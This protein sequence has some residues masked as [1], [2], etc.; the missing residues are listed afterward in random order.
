MSSKW[1]R[2]TAL[3]KGAT[4]DK[5]MPTAEDSPRSLPVRERNP[6][7]IFWICVFL[8]AMV[9]VVF[10]QT[11]RFDFVNF[12]DGQYVT[13]NPAVTSG[14]TTHGVV[15]AFSWH[16]TDNWV[17]LTTISHM[18]DCQFYGVDASGHHFTNILLHAATVILLFLTL[19]RMAGAAWR[20]A[21]VTALFAIHPLRAESVGWVSERKDVLC[22]FFFMLTL[23]TYAGYARNPR[24]VVRYVTA[25]FFAALALMSK[26]VA[27]TLPCVLL[28]L[29]YWPLN[30]F[31]Q[32]TMQRL[33]V[34]KIPF[35]I[36]SLAS[37]LPTIL[38]ERQGITMT[39]TVPIPLRIENAIISTVAYIKELFYPSKLAVFYYYPITGLPLLK[40]ALALIFL[41]AIG[42]A[43][44][45]WRRKYPYLLVGWFWYLIMLVPVIGL[46]QVGSQAH[47][48]RHTYLS[49]IGLDLLLTWL[50]ADLSTRLRHRFLILSSLSASILLVLLLCGHVQVSYWRNGGTL[51]AHALNCDPYDVR[52]YYDLANYL[53]QNKDLDG[54]LKNYEAA[55]RIDPH[56][57]AAHNN[58]GIILAAKG[59]L[60]DA[61]WQYQV[62]LKLDT[63]YAVAHYNLGSALLQRG[64]TN[65]AITEFREALNIDPA[66]SETRNNPDLA[67]PDVAATQLKTKYAQFHYSLGS[68]LETEGQLNEAIAQYKDALALNPKYPDTSYYLALDLVKMGEV[69]ES[70]RQFKNAL[71]DNPDDAKLDNN[72]GI[73]LR[74]AGRLDDAI[75][76]YREALKIAPDYAQAHYNLANAL[77]QKGEMNEAILEYQTALKNKPDNVMLQKNLAHTIWIL[78]TSPDASVRNGTNAVAFAERANALTTG[79]SPL[80]LRVLAAAYA[81]RG[82]FPLAIE[83]GK[84]AMML[85]IEQQNQ[86]LQAAL[87][88]EIS[89][90][91]SGSPVRTDPA[92]MGGW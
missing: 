63:N 7:T 85:A 18:V 55:I 33:A 45:Y 80:I 21:F 30:R 91:Q 69:D 43:A 82:N 9:W 52:A 15:S 64:E 90:Y 29:D 26:P 38:T 60:E 75:V 92:N 87:Q 56:L 17:P 28:L 34:E 89:E 11:I 23:W 31:N 13:G 65:E 44:I 46:V 20:S 3:A 66:H 76:Q 19:Y 53:D 36:L 6:W 77:L 79:S 22:G 81:E 58:L 68:A 41:T 14:L 12:D 59:D 48:D 24:S 70:I 35:L 47:A 27:V 10:G 25:L 83:A 61:M 50:I 40:V 2:K 86:P 74:K 1:N 32:L 54:A 8:L 67:L 57:V 72:F 39:T 42:L 88:Q 4:P 51:W 71:K 84:K 37:C 5:K 49:E 78:A 62:A 73:T 16:A